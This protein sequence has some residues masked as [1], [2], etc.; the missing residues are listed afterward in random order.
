MLRSTGFTLLTTLLLSALLL[1]AVG[2]VAA[3]RPLYEEPHDAPLNN[4]EEKVWEEETTDLPDYPRD[5]NL[6]EFQVDQPGSKFRYFID[7]ESISVGANDGVVRYTLVIR[8][9]SG[10]ENVMFEAMHCTE[11]QYKTFAYGTSKR[12]FR[13]L[14]RPK[15]R[16]IRETRNARYR[17][18]LWE[19][20]L[21]D[22]ETRK[23]RERQ[24]I[25]DA[26][27]YRRE[28]RPGKGF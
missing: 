10:S 9:L 27:R 13:P 19:F 14:R 23:I 21:C 22:F 24:K 17:R 2:E 15:W 6:L 25:I 20:Y 11:R 5:E 28:N 3:R 1:L 26:I 8:S 4:I 16:S 18:D 12:E 7:T